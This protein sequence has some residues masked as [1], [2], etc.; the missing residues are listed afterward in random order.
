MDFLRRE[1]RRRRETEKVLV[2]A[3]SNA[4][5]GD[6]QKAENQAKGRCQFNFVSF[7]KSRALRSAVFI[8]VYA[9]GSSSRTSRFLTCMH[10]VRNKDSLSGNANPLQQRTF[11]HVACRI[12]LLGYPAKRLARERRS[13]R[14]EMQKTKQPPPEAKTFARR[15]RSQDRRLFFAFRKERLFR[16][17]F[18]SKTF[19][20][21]K[22]KSRLR[23]RRQQGSTENSPGLSAAAT[24]DFQKKTLAFTPSQNVPAARALSQERKK[25]APREARGGIETH[26]A[27][28]SLYWQRTA[29][30]DVDV[31]DG[32]IDV[33]VVIKGWGLGRKAQSLQEK[34]QAWR[35]REFTIRP[36]AERL[37]LS[38]EAAKA[39]REV[40]LELGFASRKRALQLRSDG[41]TLKP[42]KAARNFRPF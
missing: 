34:K 42:H 18:Q 37:F 26:A 21:S 8:A 25:T 11:F 15:R 38:S 32:V 28:L 30:V 24:A 23:R 17:A 9:K 7:R 3:E 29:R 20:L 35:R 13:R 33:V 10:A 1:G 16:K 22:N 39:A 40:A 6:A 4:T 5:P 31:V 2:F 12:A 27:L 14:K 36:Q 19:R 41:E